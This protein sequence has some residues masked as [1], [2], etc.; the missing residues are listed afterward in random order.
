LYY[1]D[2]LDQLQLNPPRW[3]MLLDQV[4]CNPDQAETALR[5]HLDDHK[6]KGYLQLLAKP[7]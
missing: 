6:M 3:L 1:F 7:R 4:L 5:Q 2:D